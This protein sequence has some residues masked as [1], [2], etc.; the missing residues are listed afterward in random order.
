MRTFQLTKAL[1]LLTVLD[2]MKLGAK[3]QSGESLARAL[4]P[5][6]WRKEEREIE[7]RRS[8]C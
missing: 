5:W 8:S 7:A 2:N 4:F 1:G 3:D 6:F